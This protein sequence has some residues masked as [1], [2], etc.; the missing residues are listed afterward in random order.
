VTAVLGYAAD[1]L[2]IVALAVMAA[3]T[4]QAWSQVP[5]GTRVPV[6]LDQ[7]G[8]AAMSAGK[9]PALLA[10]PVLAFVVGIALSALRIWADKNPLAAIA[11]FL[12]RASLAPLLAVAHL[13]WLRTVLDRLQGPR[14]LRP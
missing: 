9:A 8:A 3:A 13:L 4:R 7:T 12:V 10:V 6:A 14:T 1:A 5:P 11:L 2:W